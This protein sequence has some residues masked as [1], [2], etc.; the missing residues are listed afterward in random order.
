MNAFPMPSLSAARLV[1]KEVLELP[2]QQA[3]I[4]ELPRGR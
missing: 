2:L 1:D 3:V 4:G